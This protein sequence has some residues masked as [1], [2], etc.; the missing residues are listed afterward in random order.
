MSRTMT[1]YVLR[2]YLTWF[3]AMLLTVLAVFIVADFSDRVKLFMAYSLFDV[4]QMYWN[5]SLVAINQLAPP[6]MM[7]AAGSAIATLSRRGELLAMRALSF[8]PGA[9]YLPIGGAAVI[10]AG[11][12]LAFDEAVVTRAGARVDELAVSRFNAG[13]SDWYNY[14]RPTQWFR[15]GDQVLHVGGGDVESGFQNVSLYQLSRDFRLV[16]RVDAEQMRH[17]GENRWAFTSAVLRRFGPDGTVSVQQQARSELEIA[18]PPKTLVVRSGRPE[19][20]SRAALLEQI[21]SRREIGQRVEKQ[22]LAL[23]N[24]YSYPLTGLAGTLLAI[25]LA[26]RPGRKGQLT[27][28]LV[29]GFAVAVA[30]WSMMVVGKG[31]ALAGHFPIAAASWAP[32]AMLMLG[33]AALAFRTRSPAAE[34]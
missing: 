27:R 33:A 8:G 22:L 3:A 28:A 31:L 16:S 2:L 29:E 30:M 19:Y 20:L 4:G 12:L 17:L 14:Y 11:L 24:R 7:L 10:A 34:S 32:C 9:L 18:F 15:R 1:L 26:L 21:R 6:S 5:K 13:W 23:H 25:G